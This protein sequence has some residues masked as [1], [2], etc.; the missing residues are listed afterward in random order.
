[1]FDLLDYSELIWK[2]SNPSIF[3]EFIDLH[4]D[5]GL[6]KKFGESIIPGWFL[7]FAWPA[8]CFD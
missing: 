5:L 2:S 1:L 8:F 7:N 4:D 6:I 3:V